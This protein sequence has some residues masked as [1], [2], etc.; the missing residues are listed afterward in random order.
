MKKMSEPR[1]QAIKG[2]VLYLLEFIKLN[3]V[4]ILL[5]FVMVACI[6][7]VIVITIIGIRDQQ[8]FQSDETGWNME[9]IAA[10]DLYSNNTCYL[11]YDSR[12]NIVYVLSEDGGITPYIGEN[13]RY[14]HYVD[15]NIVEE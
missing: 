15:G 1:K 13:G 10:S 9:K 6:L 14:C 8:K 3:I 4:R 11:Y 12:T 2:D 5:Y 7:F